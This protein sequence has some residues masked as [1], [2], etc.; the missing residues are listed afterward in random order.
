MMT[1]LSELK[2]IADFCCK[3]LECLQEKN[4]NSEYKSVLQR[5]KMIVTQVSL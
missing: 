4:E 5:K 3:P 2:K 1:F